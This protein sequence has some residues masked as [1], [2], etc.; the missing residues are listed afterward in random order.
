MLLNIIIFSV[1]GVISNGV[2]SYTT[3]YV[4]KED[5][6]GAREVKVYI[7]V[8]AILC[9]EQHQ[10]SNKLVGMHIAWRRRI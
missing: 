5:N 10:Q 3:G 1:L 9:P 6:D 7:K 2:P 4:T 8:R